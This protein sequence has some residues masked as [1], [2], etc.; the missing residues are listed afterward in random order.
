MDYKEGKKSLFSNKNDGIR[1]SH[2]HIMNDLVL[3]LM[4]KSPKAKLHYGGVRD[5]L[6]KPTSV[7]SVSFFS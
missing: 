7:V 2:N 5:V 6:Y 3:K 1:H 4:S